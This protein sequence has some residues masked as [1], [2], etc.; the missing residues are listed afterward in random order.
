MRVAC[1]T[2]LTVASILLSGQALALET[3]SYAMAWFTAAV[4]NQDGDCPG[5]VNPEVGDQYARNLALL[6]YSGSDVERLMADY[7]AGGAKAREVMRIMT[8]RARINGKPANAYAHPAGVID[9]KLNS[10]VGKYAYGFD[11]DG[12]VGKQSFEDPETKQAGVD[13][14]L[15]RVLGCIEPMR[16]TINNRPSFWTFIWTSMKDTTPAWLISITGED[17]NADGPVTVTFDRS[18]DHLK[19]NGTGEARHDVTY[20]IDPDPRSHHVFRG[21]IKNGVISITEHKDLKMLQDPLS[22]PEFI[23]SN[24]HLRLKILKDGA[25]DGFIGGYQPWETIYWSFAQGGIDAE[26]TITGELPGVYHLM[27]RFADA[28]PDAKGQN[29][30]ISATYRVEFVPAFA[31][32]AGPANLRA[33][34]E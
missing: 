24:T 15:F 7:E 27:R 10:I 26:Q 34:A 23:L 31:V 5:G 1:G 14:E 8:Y 30:R 3:R 22:T 16:G 19:F 25:L 20:R 29:T 2:A 28:A 17:L 4:S 6:G 18:M 9:P 33:Q 32:S 11:L 21:E 12:N 13:N